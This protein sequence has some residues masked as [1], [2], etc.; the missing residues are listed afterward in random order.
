VSALN[1]AELGYLPFSSSGVALLF[2]LL[3]KLRSTFILGI[4]AEVAQLEA[5]LISERTKARHGER[6]L[7]NIVAG[8]CRTAG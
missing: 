4:M 7:A 6:S 5:G 3:S 8:R 1:L 2:H